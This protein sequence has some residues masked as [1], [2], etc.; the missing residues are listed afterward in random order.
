MA[1]SVKLVVRIDMLDN[2][3]I[4]VHADSAYSP[5]DAFAAKVEKAVKQI[6]QEHYRDEKPDPSS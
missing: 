2:G 3:E 4:K 1:K 6:A 5:E